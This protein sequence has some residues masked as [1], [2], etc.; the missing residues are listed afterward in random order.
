LNWHF[1]AALYAPANRNFTMGIVQKLHQH[2]DRYFRMQVLL[3]HGGNKAASEHREIAD[4]VG[5]KDIPL[6]TTR[7]RAHILDA[8]RSLLELLAEQRGAKAKHAR[9]SK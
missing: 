8:G 3:V 7:M 5:A 9:D 1:H 4:A 6:A 2:S